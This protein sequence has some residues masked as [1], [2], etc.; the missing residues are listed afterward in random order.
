MFNL[1]D[2]PA[3]VMAKAQQYAERGSAELHYLQKMISA[4]AFGI[5]PP[6]N[7]VALLADIKRWGEDKVGDVVYTV[8]VSPKAL[9]KRLRWNMTA[10]VTIQSATGALSAEGDGK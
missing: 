10:S 7:Y 3:Q 8:E 6:Q 5:E 4:G 2:L 9:D 1:F